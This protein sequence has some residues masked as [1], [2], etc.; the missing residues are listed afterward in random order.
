M[1]LVV[2]MVILLIMSIL[3]VATLTSSTLQERM[4]GNSRQRTLS[5]FAAEASIKTAEQFLTANVTGNIDLA[6]FNGL[7]G[8]YSNY[9]L[10]SDGVFVNPS[11]AVIAD[12][13]DDSAWAAG[14]SIAVN[15]LSNNVVGQSPRYIIEYIGRDNPG[16]KTLFVPGDNSVQTYPHVFLITGMG[17]SR[18]SNIYS[19]LQSTY[20]TGAGVNFKY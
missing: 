12:V 17:W 10:I 20:R 13:A 14:N 4:T 7:N 16:N 18:D 6:M 9:A 2:A 15:T 3:G 11:S 19:V 8:L 5:Q 1:I